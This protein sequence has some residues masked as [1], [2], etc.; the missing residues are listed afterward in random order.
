VVVEGTGV[1]EKRFV[2][3]QAVAEVLLFRAFT[4][5]MHRTRRPM[6]LIL[7]VVPLECFKLFHTVF[8]FL[9][10]ASTKLGDKKT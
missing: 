10:F 5:S 2:V 7:I 8:L 9:T 1:V 3:V 4:C 6:L